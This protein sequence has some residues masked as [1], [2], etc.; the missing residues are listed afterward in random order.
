[1]AR[2]ISAINLGA[3]YRYVNRVD[4]QLTIISNIGVIVAHN[5]DHITDNQPAQS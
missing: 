3:F 1:M 2:R 4:A 5:G